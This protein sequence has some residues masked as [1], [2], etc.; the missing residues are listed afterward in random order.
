MEAI[1][2]AIL[3]TVTIDYNLR[4][5]FEHPENTNARGPHLR[6]LNYKHTGDLIQKS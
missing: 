3:Q 1:N 4:W 5:W 2:L 6:T